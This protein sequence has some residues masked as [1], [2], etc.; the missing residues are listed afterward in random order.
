MPIGDA[1]STISAQ[2]RCACWIQVAKPLTMPR[3]GVAVPRQLPRQPTHQHPKRLR[4]LHSRLPWKARNQVGGSCSHRQP[5]TVYLRP[6]F[7]Q[8]D[9]HRPG[10]RK[11]DC[12]RP[13]RHSLDC[14]QPD[15]RQRERRRQG[16][17]GGW[18]RLFPEVLRLRLR[19]RLLRRSS[20]DRFPLVVAATSRGHSP[21]RPG[22]PIQSRCRLGEDLRHNRGKRV[23]GHCRWQRPFLCPCQT[24]G[25]AV[26]QSIRLFR[27]PTRL[28]E[29][30]LRGRR[31]AHSQTPV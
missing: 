22:R 6:E 23:V 2:R 26:V 21:S 25:K 31:L 11:L 17:L 14:L 12:P 3:C 29:R 20:V 13:E 18:G 15:C 8:P 24:L 28:L 5:A 19:R 4:M 30:S 1:C 16:V 7:P 10:Y 27:L 9:C